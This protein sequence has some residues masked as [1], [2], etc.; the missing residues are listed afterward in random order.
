MS[1]PSLNKAAVFRDVGYAPHA[2][3]FA[4]HESRASRRVL[5]CGVRWGKTKC[6]V[7]E[8]VCALL[9]PRDRE[10]LGWVVGPDHA[11]SDR[12]LRQAH[13]VLEKHVPRRIIDY[14]HHALRVRNLAY[15][16]AV[17]EG[18]SAE[19]PASLLGEGLD[20][21][22]ID[23]AARLKNEVWDE[24]LS[25]RLV[26]RRG[27][28]LIL[29]TPRGRG[30][31]YDAYQR[32]QGSDPGYQSWTG[33]TWDNPH[34]DRDAVEGERARLEPEAFRQEYEG[35]FVGPGIPQCDVCGYPRSEFGP[36][37]IFQN[38]EE[39]GICAACGH[40]VTA[41]GRSLAFQWEDGPIVEQSITLIELRHGPRELEPGEIR[42]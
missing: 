21:L 10:S 42:P 18:R 6:A 27:W 20:W 33:P 28:A 15:R 26:E 39:P 31:F 32:G 22:V 8:V 37:P 11:V 29:S 2:G 14:R 36:I 4:V 17:A 24:H 41:D 1:I 34:I 16:V 38:G 35:K 5:A 23:E 25:Q 3:Q 30:W 9:E 12:I 7:M 13:G 19:N 40:R